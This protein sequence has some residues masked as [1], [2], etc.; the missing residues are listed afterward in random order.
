MIE[1]FEIRETL[2]LTLF[3][4]ISLKI[5]NS[6]YFSLISFFLLFLGLQGLKNS[7]NYELNR[8]YYP[9]K[10][11]GE[12]HEAYKFSFLFLL[13]ALI[14]SYYF[15]YG[16]YFLLSIFSYFFA[17]FI[18]P[19]ASFFSDFIYFLSSLFTFSIPFQLSP[20]LTHIPFLW[21]LSLILLLRKIVWDLI[22]P[23]GIENYN[24]PKMV[25]VKGARNA[26]Y[27]ICALSLLWL[28]MPALLNASLYSSLYPIPFSF[29][30]L[31]SYL[32]ATQRPNEA[33]NSLDLALFS[34]LI[35]SIFL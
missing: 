10:F 16:H 9:K 5:A 34:Y 11:K 22:R 21:T 20:S 33:R 30:L 24:L 27:L 14:T 6:N 19:K 29:I 4:L 35:V 18:K 13:L 26:F 17:F 23:Y 8:I 12:F 3:S 2:I 31:S 28:S 32:I 1:Y 25:G 15:G 7:L